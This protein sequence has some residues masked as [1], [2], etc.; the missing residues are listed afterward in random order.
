MH[1]YL[2]LKLTLQPCW[3]T[4]SLKAWHRMPCGPLFLRAAFKFGRGVH[5]ALRH[6]MWKP[7][8][9]RVQGD[10]KWTNKSPKLKD[11][12]HARRYSQVTID[13]AMND[14]NAGQF[15]ARMKKMAAQVNFYLYPN[16]FLSSELFGAW[17]LGHIY[18]IKALVT[19][20]LFYQYR[21][22][23]LKTPCIKRQ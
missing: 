8:I 16:A 10:F 21:L 5:L 3:S 17:K 6:K 14:F 12:Q 2:H 19:Y 7:P 18:Q 1:L 13:T 20:L 9:T 22:P 23:C 15:K 11:G 4:T